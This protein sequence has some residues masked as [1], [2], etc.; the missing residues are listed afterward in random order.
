[1]VLTRDARRRRDAYRAFL[2]R[3][4]HNLAAPLSSLGWLDP[5][6]NPP[7]SQTY[8]RGAYALGK[9]G[10]KIYALSL[11]LSLSRWNGCP[12]ETWAWWAGGLR[13]GAEGEGGGC[14][15]L[16]EINDVVRAG[17]RWVNKIRSGKCVCAAVWCVEG[18]V[19]LARAA[20]GLG[21]SPPY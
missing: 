19:A 10:V 3:H 14:Q 21:G 18:H 9:A 16:Q 12:R 17:R 4:P 5:S 2:Q 1:M 20:Y 13:L 11:S 6:R 15:S 7:A 8:D